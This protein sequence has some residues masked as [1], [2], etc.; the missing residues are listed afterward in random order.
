LLQG[1]R[2]NVLAV[3]DLGQVRIT[4][5]TA[6]S[7]RVSP[8]FLFA[9]L[10]GSKGDGR[11]FIGEAVHRGA[12]AILAPPGTLPP[13]P[14]EPGRAPVPLIL[15]DNP[16]RRF[17][18]LAARFYQRQPATIAA[19]TGTNGKTS[20]VWFL[21]QIW[22]RLGHPAAS[23]GTLGLTTGAGTE[24]GS[25][26]TPD[27]V[28]LHGT[29]ARL[30]AERIDWLAIE[31]SSHGLDQFRLDGLR[32]TAAAFTNLSRDHLDYHGT[33]DA[34]LAAKLRLFSAVTAPGGVAVINADV[35]EAE[36]VRTA[37][38]SGRLSVLG[39]G[40]EG[41]VLRLVDLKAVAG[42]QRLTIVAG[43][44][45]H[46]VDLPLTGDFQAA[47]ALCAAGLAIATGAATT[48]ALA[49]LET[50]EPV[51]G[52]IECVV[53]FGNGA[54]VYVDYAHTPDALAVVLGAVRRAHEGTLTLVFG[55]GGDRDAGKRPIM[56]AVARD[57]ADRIIVTDDNPRTEDPAAIRQQ[58]LAACPR[59]LE[60]ADRARAIR[61]AI[62]DLGAGDAV[63]VAGKGHETGQ[64]VGAQVLPFDDR[65]MVRTAVREIPE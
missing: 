35:P 56:G 42:G 21:R 13:P 27:P 64:I 14:A 12:A 50:L 3:A 47:N 61:T 20:V 2:S 49:A 19:V 60:I 36:A 63:V 9:A 17:A 57:G 7:R 33:V 10:P 38:R 52:R 62:R 30:A 45:T 4:G 26:T 44:R 37:A 11:L 22:S 51:P 34:Y 53:R 43:G 24:P 31:A 46:P 39:Y 40:R 23:L 6:D 8:G 32:V 28:A 1:D 55:C 5:L 15:D 65:E 54:A 29:L 59:A 25:L 58:I 48:D 16:R 41:D 18:L